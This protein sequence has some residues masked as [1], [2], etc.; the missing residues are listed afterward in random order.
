MKFPATLLKDPYLINF[1]EI[2]HK[3][4]MINSYQ[5]SKHIF[6]FGIIHIHNMHV[7]EIIMLQHCVSDLE[8]SQKST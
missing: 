2:K 4:K 5:Y 8:I 6:S 7:F 1:K 3:I